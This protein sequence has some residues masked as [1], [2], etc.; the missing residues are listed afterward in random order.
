[1]SEKLVPRVGL[2][3]QV[4]EF[5]IGGPILSLEGTVSGDGPTPTGIVTF[6]IGCMVMGNVELRDGTARLQYSGF[7]AGTQEVKAVYGGDE[8]YQGGESEPQEFTPSKAT[9]KEPTLPKSF[10]QPHKSGIQPALPLV[11]SRKEYPVKLRVNLAAQTDG[12]LPA[13]RQTIEYLALT[14]TINIAGVGTGLKHG[15]EFF[16]PG[17]EAAR[18]LKAYSDFVQL[19]D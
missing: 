8:N 9:Y 12:T 4:I 15:H 13:D 3:F 11:T 18:V 10:P 17:N 5:P 2:S 1:M 16:L 14:R 19:A 6:Q 7:K